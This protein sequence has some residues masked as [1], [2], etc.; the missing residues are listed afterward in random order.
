M[1]M[2][3]KFGYIPVSLILY[4]ISLN[5]NNAIASYGNK[6]ILALGYIS[7][8]WLIT[9]VFGIAVSLEFIYLYVEGMIRG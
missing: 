5:T 7:S 4:I 3:S 8:W 9:L 6:P 1:E 2:G